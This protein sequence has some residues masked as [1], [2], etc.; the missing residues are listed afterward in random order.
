[1]SYLVRT[2]LEIC[3]AA[4][5]VVYISVKVKGVEKKNNAPRCEG[6]SVTAIH[7]RSV[8]IISATLPVILDILG[9]RK[10]LHDSIRR[11]RIFSLSA[12]IIN[13]PQTDC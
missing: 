10:I 8:I 12:N 5:F 9:V 13:E 3:I 11:S 4:V 2:V 6:R 1:M 7:H